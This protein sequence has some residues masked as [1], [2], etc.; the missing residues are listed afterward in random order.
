M[1]NIIK[2][3]ICLLLIC[4]F[5]FLTKIYIFYKNECNSSNNIKNNEYDYEYE[6]FIGLLEIVSNT[7]GGKYDKRPKTFTEAVNN[8]ELIKKET[9]H[10]YIKNNSNKLHKSNDYYLYNKKKYNYAK[11]NIVNNKLIIFDKNNN[12]I[13]QLIKHYYN[14]Y[15]IESDIFL[16]KEI[17]VNFTNHFKDAK[18]NIINNNKYFYVKK[19]SFDEEYIIYMYALKIGKIKIIRSFNENPIYKIIVYEEY[20]EYLNIFAT[21]FTMC[22][23]LNK[24]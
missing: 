22:E 5:L 19:N 8:Q 18:I 16:N 14:D 10:I 15:S 20:K 23:N 9:R 7:V 17:T 1:N 2:L 13:G 4:Y 11:I 12:K 6:N 21:V 24:D 3:F